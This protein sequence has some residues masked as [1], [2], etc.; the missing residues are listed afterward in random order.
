MKPVRR[1][2]SGLIR[3]TEDD[4]AI[5]NADDV[6]P[7]VARRKDGLSVTSQK[8][9]GVDPRILLSW[10]ADFRYWSEGYRLLGFRS[11]TGFAPE[12]HPEK[13]ADHGQMILEETADGCLEERLS[14]GTHFYTFVLYRRKFLGLFENMSV[15]RF[16]ETIPS[17]RVAIGRIED[18]RKL[19]QLQEDC[20][21]HGIKSQLAK[22][23]ALIALH[24]SNKK[25]AA[26][27]ETKQDDSLD[28]Q[29]RR[30]VESIVRKKLKRA[31]TRV[32]LVVALQDV[33]KRLKR[34]PAWKK[35]ARQEQDRLL[36]VIIGDLDSQ[37]EFF[38]P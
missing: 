35:L 5:Q 20:E 25:L 27:T 13:L 38:Q 23:E 19:Q 34:N 18:Q 33:Q 15:V 11:A 8:C 16:S 12:Q 1:V 9:L 30:E 37:E 10:Q 14:E 31:M 17:A 4:G 22:N 3:A 32:E 7:P 26:L 24:Q 28:E 21:L 36:Q 29:V 2:S 6:L